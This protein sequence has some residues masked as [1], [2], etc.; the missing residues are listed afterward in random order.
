MLSGLI[1]KFKIPV[2]FI[3]PLCPSLCISLQ[4]WQIYRSGEVEC[5]TIH[6][7][8]SNAQSHNQVNI[9]NVVS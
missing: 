8:P 4:A 9:S 2:P 3:W 1:T 7:S 5:A 6:V